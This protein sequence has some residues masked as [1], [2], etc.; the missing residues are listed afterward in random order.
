VKKM[1][2]PINMFLLRMPRLDQSDSNFSNFCH[3]SVPMLNFRVHV[4]HYFAGVGLSLCG[5]PSIQV[6]RKPQIMAQWTWSPTR[7]YS[8][9][10]IHCLS[11]SQAST[12]VETSGEMIQSLL[13]SV[14]MG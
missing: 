7:Y 6:E 12:G 5:R 8:G 9:R 11:T 1:P 14:I 2:E 10:R 13:H 3:C 4:Q